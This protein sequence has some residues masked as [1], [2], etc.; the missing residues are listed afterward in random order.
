MIVVKQ[1]QFTWIHLHNAK[2]G[3]IQRLQ[4]EYDFHELI[5]EDLIELSGENK[6][7][8]YEDDQVVSMLMNFPKYD[9]K[10][11]KYH[12]HPFVII[13]SEKYV[14]SLSKYTSKHLDN[15]IQRAQKPD[16]LAQDMATPTFDLVYDIIDT[17]YDKSVKGLVK[18]GQDVVKI[19]DS[20]EAHRGLSKEILDE[21]MARKINM[22][23]LQHIFRP[24][25]QIL[26]EFKS[27][28]KKIL[29]TDEEE[30]EDAKLY[31]E[32]LDSKLD[33]ILDGISLNY[34]SLKALADT[35]R[36]V[37]DLQTNRN[38]SRLTMITIGL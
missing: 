8:Y 33:K 16:Y 20:I 24:Q 38:I 25:R 4:E 17:M 12:H 32:D 7:E 1:P 22:V 34:E 5:E 2:P 10:L 18:A 28:I 9:T 15:L 27:S 21:I 14:L 3:D 6:V 26:H 30:V 31:V 36:A 37:I 29:R 23:T 19:Q 35:Y 13:V 11:Q